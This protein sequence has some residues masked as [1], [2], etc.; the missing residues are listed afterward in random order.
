AATNPH[1]ASPEARSVEEV[2]TVSDSNRVLAEPYTR[3]LVARDQVNQ[4]AGVVVMSVAKAT[5][6]GI[7]PAHWVFVHGH[8]DLRERPLMERVDLSTSPASIA[9]MNTALNMAGLT[10]DDIAF[11][12]F[13][14]CFPIAVFNI[15]DAFGLRADDPRGLT[16][17]GGLPYFGGPGNNYSMHAIA[18]VVDRVRS[19]PGT[20]GLV[21][22]NGGL[23]SKYSV[24]IYATTPTPWQAGDDARIQR[25]L[26]S[27]PSV[28]ERRNADG[29]ATIES[30]TVLPA[31]KNGRRKSI[32]VVGRLGDG[33]RFVANGAEGDDEL[34]ELL[35]GSDDPIGSPIYVRSFARGNRV[36]VSDARMSE[37]FPVRPSGFREKYE[38]VVIRR[39]GR[40][41]EVTIN[42]PAARNAL[43]PAANAELDEIFDA[44]FADPDL[45]VAILTG[46]GDKAFSAGND[47]AH[48]AGDAMLAVPKNGFGGLTS[49]RELPKPVIAAVNGVALG[50][51]LEIA[52]A[53]HI[54]VA[55]EKASFGLPEVKVGLAAAAGGLVRLPRAI[56][57]ALARDMILTGRRI[58]TAEAYRIGLV[59]R[60][61]DHGQVLVAAR[62]VAQE[63]LAGSPTSVRASLQA[64]ADAEAIDDP[65]EAIEAT[66]S[67]LDSLLISQ[68]TIEGIS[69]FVS[70]RPP[71]WTGR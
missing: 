48:M 57:P 63:I 43:D 19:R 47:L 13:Y 12:D 45:W 41:L 8:S 64:M 42:R 34:L 15:C 51:G 33:A 1:A 21:A 9:A 26:D 65:V 30:F 55:D 25:E 67:V 5:A 40:V 61:A 36:A 17:T 46:A 10:L 59:S 71:R 7:D 24:G 50:G 27:R 60:I 3:L 20:F 49:R 39:D 22:A 44:Y 16:V 66:S 35:T 28:D 37:L 62:Q 11:L 58:D 54:I 70:K 32:V 2:A 23:M 14:S 69:A 52:L 6:L 53:C 18:E 68:D 31:D 29:A 38:N 56:G 4:A